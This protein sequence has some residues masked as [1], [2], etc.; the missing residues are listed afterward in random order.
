MLRREANSDKMN[1]IDYNITPW[2]K[3]ITHP[4]VRDA[5]SYKGKLFRRR[6]PI[7]FPVFEHLIDVCEEHNIFDVKMKHKELIPVSIELLCCLRM[8][9]RG[10][11]ADDIAEVAQ[12]GESTVNAIFK[13]FCRNFRKVMQPLHIPTPNDDEILKVMDVYARLG[14]SGTAGS[15]D[16]THIK[17]DQCPVRLQALCTG[18]E[19]FPTLGFQAV[20]DH[21]R[22]TL[23]VTDAFYGSYNDK[24]LSNFDSFIYGLRKRTLYRDVEY[25]IYDEHG[26]SHILKD[27]HVFCDSGYQ[28]EFVL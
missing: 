26:V 20:V 1:R 25:S 2:G 11:C 22:R 18:K 19:K 17:W 14:L 9:G 7:P 28:H 15:V 6:F 24:N 16:G 27:V 23:H 21:S 5:S 3:L 8:L 10:N 12:V 13:V 4:S